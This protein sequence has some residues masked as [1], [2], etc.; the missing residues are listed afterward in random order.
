MTNI[1]N[2]LSIS[3]EALSPTRPS[4]F[5]EFLR[6]YGSGTELFHLL[7]QKNGFY[8]FEFALHVF[9]LSNDPT[10]GLQ[11]WNAESLWRSSYGDL[12]EGLLFFGEDILQD[13]FCLRKSGPGVYRFHAETGRT[14]F[15]AESVEKWA[16]LILSDYKTETGWPFA[17]EW[18]NKNGALSFGQRLMPKMPF[19]LGGEYNLEN[20]WAGNPLEG[21]R[22]KGELATQTRDLPHG[23]PVR[24]IISPKP[25]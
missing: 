14:T 15:M 25:R 7:E 9:P 3:S 8:A 16:G 22:F 13:Q 21:M 18:Q 19:L 2:L 23:A 24:L 10:M 12:A 1:Q 11:G 20:L 17:H 6:E 4:G 5:P